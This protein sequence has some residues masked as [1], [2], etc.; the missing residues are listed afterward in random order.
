MSIII[1]WIEDTSTPTF[2]NFSEPKCRRFSDIQ[3]T[4]ALAFANAKR[5][6]PTA[7]YVVISSQSS[8]RVG[9]S[10]VDSVEDGRLPNGDD[11]DWK[12]RR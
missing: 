11:Y 2:P 1:F 8:D 4:E 7:S 10:G 3:L 5:K 9:Q 12:K 6:E